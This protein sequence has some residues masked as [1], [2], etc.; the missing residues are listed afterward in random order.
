MVHM[1][2]KTVMLAGLLVSAAVYIPVAAEELELIRNSDFSKVTPKGLPKEWV[3]GK[4]AQGGIT[5]DPA[6]KCLRLKCP[7]NGKTASFMQ[8]GIPV[9]SGQ[10]YLLT[11]FF[12]GSTGSKFSAY[13]E[14]SKPDWQTK[15]SAW[16]TCSDEWKKLSLRFNFEKLAERPWLVLRVKGSGEVLIRRPA[17]SDGSVPVNGKFTNGTNGWSLRGGSVVDT[18]RNHGKS[19]ELNSAS[20]PA[21]ASQTGIFVKKGSYYALRWQVRGGSDKTHR[22]PQNAVWFRGT[23]IMNGKSLTPDTWLDCFDGWQK[24]SVVFQAPASGEV[25]ILMEAKPP[26]CV[27]FDN[28]EFAETKAPEPPLV[29]LPNAPFA[30]RN[31]VYSS[32]RQTSKAKYILLNNS[33]P[34]TASY[35]I[36]FNGKQFRIKAEKN[37]A[38]ELDVPADPGIY[39]IQADALDAAGKI[40]ASVSLPLQ[41]NPPAPREVTFREDYVMLINGEPFFPLGVWSVGGTKTNHEKAKLIAEAGFNTARTTELLA[42]D[43]AEYGMM[44]LL[45]VPETLPKFK[46]AE[47]FV[48]WDRKFRAEMKKMQTHPSLI[49]YYNCDEPAWGGAHLG[50]LLEAYQY[51]RKIDPYRPIMLNEAPRGEIHKIRPYSAGC[52]TY[53]V[54]IYPVPEPNPH[55]GLTDKNMTAVGKYVDRCREVV[56]GRKPVWM[57]LQAFAWGDITPKP[58]PLVYPTEHQNRFMAYNAVVHGATGL[59]WWGIN[60]G[61][62][63]NWDFVRRLGKTVWELR[64]MSAVFVAETVQPAILKASVPEVR[65]LHKRLNGT[66]WYI[67][68]NESKKELAVSFSH[69]V[70]KPLNVFFENRK[71]VPAAGQFQDSFKAYDVHIY[72][73]AETLPAPLKIPAT[74]RVKPRVDVP[75]DYRN[76]NWIW[77]PGKSQTPWHKAYFKREIMLDSQPEKAIFFC[78][79]DDIYRLY[80]NGRLVMEGGGWSRLSFRDAAQFLRPGKNTILIKAADKGI[81]PCGLLYAAVILEKN[82]KVT[83]I[84][85]D[86][87]TYASED[88]RNWVNAEILCKIGNSPWSMLSTPQ[89]ANTA[90]S[91]Q[92]DFPF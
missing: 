19:L 86:S 23:V 24:K 52:D 18:D 58:K 63:E 31:G 83:K 26:Y 32:N 13:I 42:D 53:G 90:D 45:R 17:V 34:E 43:F 10:D 6:G 40:L 12:K 2:L 59:F 56:Y 89:P 69:A 16:Q 67:A 81:A 9:K 38:F 11:V 39:P 66:D 41:V 75:D 88:N 65:I 87:K 70:E 3:P 35:A 50:K 71:I 29:L 22:D 78:A 61:R 80:L 79:A 68:V 28:I 51:V 77:Y 1:N 46:N 7:E 91:G 60:R 74:H 20:A 21:Q 92:E 5:D 82:G 8:L 48:R 85:A 49:G 15:S 47:Q 76:T 57:T 64:K 36:R 4:G 72:S 30:F 54:D 62:T 27:D 33:L 37:A 73:S 14:A 25:S 44:V 84:Y 55:S